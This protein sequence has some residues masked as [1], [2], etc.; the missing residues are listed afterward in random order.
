MDDF[1]LLDELDDDDRQTVSDLF[2]KVDV[3]LRWLDL[4]AR[5]RARRNRKDVA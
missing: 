2:F 5:R 1:D 4:Q 3:E